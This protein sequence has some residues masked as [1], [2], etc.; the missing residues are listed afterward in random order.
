MV[1]ENALENGS[2]RHANL[3]LDT[4]ALR[5]QDESTLPSRSGAVGDG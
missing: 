2:A 1:M 5:L 4:P 3:P